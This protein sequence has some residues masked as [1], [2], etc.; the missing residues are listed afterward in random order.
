MPQLFTN[1]PWQV[2][3]FRAITLTVLFGGGTNNQLLPFLHFQEPSAKS[4]SSNSRPYSFSSFSPLLCH[5]VPWNM[6]K[7]RGKQWKTSNHPVRLQF[8]ASKHPFGDNLAVLGLLVLHPLERCSRIHMHSWN[9]LYLLSLKHTQNIR[10]SFFTRM[11]CT[12]NIPHKEKRKTPEP[13]H[14]NPQDPFREK[15]H[16]PVPSLLP[17]ELLL[18]CLPLRSEVT[19]GRPSTSCQA[20]EVTLGGLWILARKLVQAQAQEQQQMVKLKIFPENESTPM[21]PDNG[22]DCCCSQ[23]PAATCSDHGKWGTL[24]EPLLRSQG[25]PHCTAQSGGSAGQDAGVALWNHQSWD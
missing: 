5:A 4:P 23:L 10:I 24:P 11:S 18:F 16:L 17:S 15:E 25:C 14:E 7:K 21:P 8:C 12:A 3:H 19:L 6:A 2:V 13:L 1:H 9:S 22:G 20:G